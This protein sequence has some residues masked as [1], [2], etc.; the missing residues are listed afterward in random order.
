[1]M[2]S[3]CIFPSF[4]LLRLVA[5]TPRI[6]VINMG[7][8]RGGPK[9]PSSPKILENIVILCFERRFSKQNSVIRLKSNILTPQNFLPPPK[10]LGWLHHRSLVNVRKIENFQCCSV[11]CKQK[12][13]VEID[14]IK[15]FFQF[16]KLN[17]EITRLAISM[18]NDILFKQ[19]YQSLAIR[20]KP[21]VNKPLSSSGLLITPSKGIVHG[22]LFEWSE[23]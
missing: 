5:T 1:M 7:V 9:G 10:Y 11:L 13:Q 8:A 6:V 2:C 4:C 18:A 20:S 23:Y 12:C 3:E 14:H 21:L 15:L 16:I 17:E 19:K 22:E